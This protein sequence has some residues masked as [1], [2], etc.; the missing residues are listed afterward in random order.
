M[1]R[2]TFQRALF[3]ALVFACLN[4][5]P[6]WAEN[7]SK[8]NGPELLESA[9]S[10]FQKGDFSQ[11]EK[12]WTTALESPEL[13]S[14]QI[15]NARFA[16]ART[17]MARKDYPGAREAFE[18]LAQ[19]ADT[20]VSVRGEALLSVGHTFWREGRFAEAAEVFE[21]TAKRDDLTRLHCWEAADRAREMRRLAKGL[22]AR[23]PKASRTPLAKVP[24]P[25]TVLYV[26]P[27]GK[28]TNPGT[29]EK[30]LG[31]L[32]QAVER[33]RQLRREKK[34]GPGGIEVLFRGGEYPVCETVHL[35]EADSGTADAPVVLRAYLGE[36]PV[37]T[38]GVALR[39]FK[40]VDDP[41]ILRRL[42]EESRGKVVQVDLKKL[43]IS[44][45]PPMGRRG[46]KCNGPD[47]KPWVELYV[48]G[49]PQT[50]ARWPND[51]F[52]KIGKVHQAELKNWREPP[53]GKAGI[54]E[55]Q[56]EDFRQSRWTEA[57]DAWLFGYWAHLWAINSR[58]ID[59]IDPVE[60]R[61]EM[62]P[63]TGYDYRKGN[64]YYAFN[65]LEEIDMPGE[66]Y[67]NRK[68]GTLYF[69]PPGKLDE[70]QVQLSTL[71][72]PFLETHGTSHLRV[73]GLTFELGCGDG[74]KIYDGQSVLLIGCTFQRLGNWGVSIQG[75]KGHGL[76]SCDLAILGG[77]GVFLKG[78]NKARLIPAGHFIENCHIHDFTRIDRSYAPAAIIDGV[79]NRM[80]HNL[81][82]DSP[83][84]GI[85]LEGYEHLVELN[86]VCDVV[87]ESD[88]QSGID[89]FGNPALRGNVIRYNFWHHNGGDHLPC[90]QAG[91]RLDDMISAVTMYGNVFWDTARGHFGGIQIN[92]G[93][94]NVAAN[95]LFIDCS[96]AFSFNQWRKEYWLKHMNK[97]LCHDLI[98]RDGVKPTE[99]PHVTKYPD[100]AHLE[101][102][103]SHNYVWRNV[104][105]D[106]PKFALR[107]KGQNELLENVRLSQD[108]GFVTAAT[109]N[110]TLPTDSVLYDL[111]GFRP[112]PFDEIGLYENENRTTLPPE[113]ANRTK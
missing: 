85:R 40:P 77:G 63:C 108:P 49:K 55:Y 113:T 26:A 58:K 36:K 21:N 110:F 53:S 70:A 67:L 102:K 8:S 99:P 101:E 111:L 3:A 80:T 71:A 9:E 74:A 90:G 12:Q 29:Q 92:G 43:G 107:E 61:I 27:N 28:A 68:T 75:G 91:I 16:I 93:K 52:V 10:L 44:Q 47:A 15:W 23:D 30:P 76:H 84:H 24:R 88:D 106:C 51:G 14:Q 94:E 41:E 11:A 35:T 50:L 81:V 96:A 64:P 100:L 7:A 72:G 34:I 17:Q 65:L 19:T 4:G 82:H 73:E 33:I 1:R 20:P 69:Y 87:Q 98:Y 97:G 25:S 112:I 57:D 62:E 38:G 37:F 31:S 59:R 109:G 78:G 103:I 13:T 60:K 42:P 2:D 6:S 46:Y 22:P 104:T 5:L 79:G 86:E 56:N 45:L 105:F 83:H 32:A 39:G 48:E 95:N 18:K 89:M 54:F 66:W